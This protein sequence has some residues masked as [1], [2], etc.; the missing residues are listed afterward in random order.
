MELQLQRLV[1]K[2]DD[3]KVENIGSINLFPFSNKFQTKSSMQS[4]VPCGFNAVLVPVPY[5]IFP[6]YLSFQIRNYL[7]TCRDN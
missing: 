5:Y 4:F 6:I 3:G 7:M 1:P 2:W